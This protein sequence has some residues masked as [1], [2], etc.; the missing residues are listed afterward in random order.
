MGMGEKTVDAIYDACKT[1]APDAKEL[2]SALRSLYPKS[3]PDRVKPFG[4]LLDMAT[5]PSWEFPGRS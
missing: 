1:H 5:V 4:R 3:F 2:A